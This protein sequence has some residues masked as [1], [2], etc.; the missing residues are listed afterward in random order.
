M[1]KKVKK[2]KDDMYQEYEVQEL[3]YLTFTIEELEAKIEHL[4]YLLVEAIKIRDKD[5]E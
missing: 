5:K 3:P 2:I 4:Q 1:T